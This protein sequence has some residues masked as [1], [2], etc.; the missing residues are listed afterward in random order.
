[1]GRLGPS[2][3]VL[4]RTL[5][6][7]SPS[8]ATSMLRRDQPTGSAA[9]LLAM[10]LDRFGC[11]HHFMEIRVPWLEVTLWFVPE[12]RDADLLGREGVHR[13]RV[14]TARELIALMA[15]PDRIPATVRSL[16][17]AK[18]A[19]DGDLV[20]VQ[21]RADSLRR[22]EGVGE[23]GADHRHRVVRRHRQPRDRL[24]R[25][26]ATDLRGRHGRRVHGLGGSGRLADRAA[27]DDRSGPR[28][29]GSR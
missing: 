22:P 26:H 21:P 23:G 11:E 20:D 10:P 29:A 9:D 8:T 18:L 14:W 5:S 2:L 17:R 19:I 28:T 13:G 4:A 15:L 3:R 7:A 25:L 27:R 24:R 12:E 1:M 6:D 16:A